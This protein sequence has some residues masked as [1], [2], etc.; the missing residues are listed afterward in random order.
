MEEQQ[1]KDLTVIQV[2]KYTSPCLS[3][4]VIFATTWK[5]REDNILSEIIHTEEDKYCMISHRDRI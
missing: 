2:V 3:E 1:I 5:T 4:E